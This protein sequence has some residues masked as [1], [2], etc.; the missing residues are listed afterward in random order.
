[1]TGV[2]E[3]PAPLPFDVVVRGGGEKRKGREKREEKRLSKPQ[4]G[5]G[6]SPTR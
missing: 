2:G 5:V 3:L 4:R 6:S 1:V